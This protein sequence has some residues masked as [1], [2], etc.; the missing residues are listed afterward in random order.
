MNIK[1]KPIASWGIWAGSLSLIMGFVTR[2]HIMTGFQSDE[3]GM[4]YVIATLFIIGLVASFRAAMKLHTE[5]GVLEKTSKTN[6]ISPKNTQSGLTDIFNRLADYQ[7]KGKTVDI[8]TIIDTYH[9]KHNSRVRS[10]SIMAALLISMG[11]L[12]TVIGLIMSISG[13][14]GMVENIGLSRS[15]M[16]EA[17]KNTVAGMGTA[18]Y[19]T[20]FGALGGLILRAVAVSQLNSLSEL[21]AAATEY[22]SLNLVAELKDK[23]EEINEQV[24][25]IVESFEKMHIEMDALTNSISS[26]IDTMMSRFG[27]TLETAGLRTL[28]NTSECISGVTDQMNAFSLELG[29]SLGAFNESIIKGGDEVSEAVTVINSAIEKSGGS[30]EEAFGEYINSMNDQMGTF[31]LK[32]GESLETFNESIIKGGDEVSEAV[33]GINSTIEKSG[34]ILEEAFIEMKELIGNSG[35]GVSGSFGGLNESVQQ[36]S[37]TVAGSLANF[38]MSI[39]DTSTELNEAVGELHSVIGQATG[40]MISMAKA[41]LD[42]E[43][44]EIAGQLAVAADS[45]KKLFGQNSDD[46]NNNQKVA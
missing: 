23:D 22:C 10:I 21:C 37:E 5:W 8:H 44:A 6:T 28:E 36:A 27:E 30:I 4:S 17:L 20:F 46:S 26:N 19:T 14:G 11:L 15:T 2:K 12:G 32:F 24:S 35:E 3:T 34:G 43:A 25:K 1:I 41:K 33:S 38:K 40:E 29:T 9:A 18:F 45:I 13:L 42:T 31:S 39:D 7:G 16:L